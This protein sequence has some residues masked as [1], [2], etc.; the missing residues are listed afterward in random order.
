ML[1]APDAGIYICG[2]ET[3]QLPTGYVVFEHEV[4]NR[5]HSHSQYIRTCIVLPNQLGHSW[6][7]PHSGKGIWWLRTLG[8]DAGI[9]LGVPGYSLQK[10]P[11]ILEHRTNN[12]CQDRGA[13]LLDEQ[14]ES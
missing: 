11:S 13:I 5:K 4:S 9:G 3:G 8:S 6:E 1:Y 14:M 2:N 10:S 7:N 12:L